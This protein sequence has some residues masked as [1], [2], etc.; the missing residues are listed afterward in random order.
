MKSFAKVNIFLKITGK[1][2]N[3]HTLISRFMIVKNLFDTITFEKSS[4]EGFSLD[5]KFSCPLEKNSIYK[6]YTLLKEHT[7]N[8]DIDE[9]FK[10]HKIA[11]QKSI[12]E[13]AGLGG[14]SSNAG[15]VLNMINQELN[16]NLSKDELSNIGAKIGA[17]VPF[18]VHGYDSAN[19]S[20]IGEIVEPYEENILDI[21][22]FTPAIECDTPSV[23]KEF[24][25]NF[26]KEYKEIEKIKKIDSIEYLKTHNIDQANDL[27]LPAVSLYPKLEPYKDK[28][29]YFSGSG[30]TFFNILE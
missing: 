2:E 3:Y 24:S 11:V 18:F 21:E 7:N 16:L 28:Y 25:K 26:Y 23:Y 9:F 6:A 12:P 15:T 27:Y 30:S 4:Q 13:F 14:G 17:D 19:V 20:G 29:S 5:G 1:R 10:S 8:P 22:T